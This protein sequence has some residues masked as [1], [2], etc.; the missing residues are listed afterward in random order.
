MILV[1]ACLAGVPCRYDGKS[2][3]DREVIGLLPEGEA[4]ALCPEELGGLPT[5][6][7]P[8]EFVGGTGEDVL[9]GKA[10]VVCRNGED[11]TE[12]FVSG[13]E[14]VL[15]VV[16]DLGVSHAIFR[17]RSPS[18]GRGR[19]YVEGKLVKGDGVCTAL[20]L[21]NGCKVTAKGS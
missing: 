13:A 11:V 10:R 8:A 19:V 12:S 7:S 3:P 6:R 20:L 16:R 1:S 4:V 9:D 14:A 17:A 21:Q 18:C 5:P 15:R 2:C